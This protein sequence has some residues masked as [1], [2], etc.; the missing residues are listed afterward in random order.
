MIL[1]HST[2]EA[3]VGSVSLPADVEWVRYYQDGQMCRWGPLHFEGDVKRVAVGGVWQQLV[4]HPSGTVLT[5]PSKL[6][7]DFSRSD[8]ILKASSPDFSVTFSAEQ[9][10]YEDVDGYIEFYQNRFYTNEF[11]LESNGLVLLEDQTIRTAGF[12]TRLLTLQ[13]KGERGCLPYTVY[14]FAYQRTGG[15][16]YNRYLFRGN[17][18]SDAYRSTVSDIL[19][20]YTRV[21]ARGKALPQLDTI[22]RAEPFWDWETLNLWKR[23]RVQETLDWG[24]FVENVFFTGIHETIPEM[25]R[26]IGKAFDVVLMYIQLGVPLELSGMY[27]AHRQKKVIELTVQVCHNNNQNV[28]GYTPMLSLVAGHM[29][30]AIRNLASQLKDF[31]HPVLFRLNNEMNSD[32]TSYSGII[33]LGDPDIYVLAWQRIYEVFR[34]E[35]VRNA[36]WV[37]NPNDRNYPPSNWND[38][39]CYWPGGEYVQMLGITGYNTGDYYRNVTGEVWREFS[40]IYD[41]IARKFL[42]LFEDYPWIITE[43]A[44][45]SYGGNKAR[46]IDRMFASISR[47]PNIKVAVWWSYADYDTRPGR[48]HIAARPYFLDET[49]ETIEA[50]ASGRN[51]E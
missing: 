11:F 49:N 32:W 7:W 8:R 40:N 48:E 31:K 18:H 13:Y 50:F 3:S 44:S 30:D 51:K 41:E 26:R 14:T 38:F 2:A 16:G 23:Y 43:F 33:T 25:E 17:E 19:N 27:E 36:I 1:M 37:F 24:I 20:S 5:V 6:S 29:D 10:P 12:S 45:S 4:D 9:S 15:R 35:G 42:P 28:Y 34:E 47:Y 21:R 46:W 22:P 39:S